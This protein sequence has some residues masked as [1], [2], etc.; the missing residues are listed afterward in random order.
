M[1]LVDCPTDS[2]HIDGS[3]SVSIENPEISL[4][5]SQSAHQI[6]SLDQEDMTLTGIESRFRSH[7]VSAVEGKEVFKCSSCAKICL[8]LV[9]IITPFCGWQHP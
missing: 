4:I 9:K 3:K 8:R 1:L 5:P 6:T 2:T 7:S